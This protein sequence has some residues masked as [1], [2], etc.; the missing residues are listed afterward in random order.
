MSQ[1]AIKNIALAIRSMG[2][3]DNGS[4]A[5]A[6]A[7]AYALP[8]LPADADFKFAFRR[9]Y[10]AQVASLIGKVNEIQV[11]D[12][13]A[14]L[15]KVEVLFVKRMQ[16]TYSPL[17]CQECVLTEDYASTGYAEVAAAVSNALK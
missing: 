11:V 17:V 15:E 6:A 14:T 3:N 12:Y 8:V 9:Q 5:L 13:Q 2:A 16:A 7:I 4:L 10:E 1:M